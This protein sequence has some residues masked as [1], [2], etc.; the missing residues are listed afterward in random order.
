MYTEM[1]LAKFSKLKIINFLSKRS[2]DELQRSCE[3]D[4]FFYPAGLYNQTQMKS[5]NARL[6]NVFQKQKLEIC[7][8]HVLGEGGTLKATSTV[9]FGLQPTLT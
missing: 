8:P 2:W 1:S 7:N 9:A 4:F 3:W 5:K 6:T